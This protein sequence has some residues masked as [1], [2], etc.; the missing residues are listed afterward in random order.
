[1]EHE[2]MKI[3]FVHLG[4]APA[5]HLWA[6]IRRLEKKF[7]NIEIVLVSDLERSEL[8]SHPRIEFFKYIRPA[9]Y[10]EQLSKLNYEFKFRSGFWQYTLERLLA[11][12][13]YH[14]TFPQK[15][16]MHLE[17][18]VLLLDGFP[19]QIFEQQTKMSWL[20]VD[21]NRDVATLVYLPNAQATKILSDALLAYLS[22]DPTLT[23]MKFLREFRINNPT[24]VLLAPSLSIE[25]ANLLISNSEI[26]S[27]IGLELSSSSKVFGGIFDPAAIGMW[28]AGSDPRNYYGSRKLFDTRE[29]LEGG[30]FINPARFKYRLSDNEE[31]YIS[32]NNIESRVWSLHIH[33]K[34]LRLFGNSS[35]AR[36]KELVTLSKM[37]K[38]HSEFDLKCLLGLLRENFR[39]KTLIGLILH[40]PR[41]RWLKSSLFLVRGTIRRVI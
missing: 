32:I 40:H 25:L 5:E 22:S 13:Q 27:Q 30:T 2:K 31:L 35:E 28:L 12:Y 3:V 33:S 8:T 21:E 18:D 19:F 4:N 10:K 36:L 37:D 20:S 39:N 41:L 11:L 15:K 34:D 14:Q 9:A 6:N 26:D 23:D 17:S 16:I 29:I 1:M 38:V 7:A 24:E